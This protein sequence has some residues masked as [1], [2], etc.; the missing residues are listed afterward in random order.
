MK[1]NCTWPLV[2]AS[3]S[4]LS[5]TNLNHSQEEKVGLF[6]LQF[7]GAAV[8]KGLWVWFHSTNLWYDIIDKLFWTINVQSHIEEKYR[9]SLEC[10]EL[11]GW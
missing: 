4:A 2:W 3:T 8:A 5:N 6:L 10:V 7:W 1:S 9:D 11:F